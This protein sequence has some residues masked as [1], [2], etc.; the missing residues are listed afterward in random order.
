[1][2]AGLVLCSAL[3]WAACR[4]YETEPLALDVTVQ[5]DR[6]TAAPGDSLQFD[7]RAQ[8]GTLLGVE[9]SWGDG[10]SL[11]ISASGAHTLRTVQRHAFANPGVY[12]VTAT[13]SDAIAGNKAAQLSVR[14]Q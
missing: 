9:I 8:G 11:A 14:I 7:I 10:M 13:V 2:R 5:S 6:T 4:P 3:L 1:M 12:D